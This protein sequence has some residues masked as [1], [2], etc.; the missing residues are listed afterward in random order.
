MVKYSVLA[1]NTSLSCQNSSNTCSIKNNCIMK[2]KLFSSGFQSQSLHVNFAINLLFISTRN[3]DVLTPKSSIS[4][5]YFSST[6]TL[7][8]GEVV[9]KVP[10]KKLH[11][12]TTDC[13]MNVKN[14]S[15][16]RLQTPHL[17]SLFSLPQISKL[18]F[19]NSGYFLT[20]SYTSRFICCTL[21]ESSSPLPFLF[22]KTVC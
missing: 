20:T 19:I 18:R 11:L 10:T 12:K 2:P 5:D 14:L 4:W 17:K 22:H 7:E 6:C 1:I 15:H 3:T 16:S 21:D 13:G 9:P 8:V